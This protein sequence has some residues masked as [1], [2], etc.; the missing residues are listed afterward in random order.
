MRIGLGSRV[1]VLEVRVEGLTLFPNPFLLLRSVRVCYLACEYCTF[2][3]KLSKITELTLPKIG[4]L[5]RPRIT[6]TVALHEHSMNSTLNSLNLGS[7]IG[8]YAGEYIGVT[9]GGYGEFGLYLL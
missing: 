6:R 8:D 2:G 5:H 9:N 4:S 3:G 1:W 7:Y